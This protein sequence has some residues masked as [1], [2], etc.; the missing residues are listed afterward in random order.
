[1]CGLLGYAPFDRAYEE[2]FIEVHPVAL[3]QRTEGAVSL[4]PEVEIESSTARFAGASW[5]GFFAF[6]STSFLELCLPAPSL[7]TRRRL[8]SWGDRGWDGILDR[9]QRAEVGEQGSEIRVGELA[10]IV[11]GHRRENGTADP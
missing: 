7:S 4:R 9:L 1:M 5:Q 3:S 8:S 10:D 11:P 2:R 6:R